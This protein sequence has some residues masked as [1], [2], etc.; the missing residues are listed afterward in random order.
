MR[1]IKKDEAESLKDYHVS[2]SPN[3]QSQGKPG[4]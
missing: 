3:F 4:G 2:F 1:N